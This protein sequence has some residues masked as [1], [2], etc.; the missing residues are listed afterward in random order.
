MSVL[1]FVIHVP[2]GFVSPSVDEQRLSVGVLLMADIFHFMAVN[3]CKLEHELHIHTR[4]GAETHTFHQCRCL[5][6]AGI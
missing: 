6:E 5:F 3:S 4:I 2:L 1:L